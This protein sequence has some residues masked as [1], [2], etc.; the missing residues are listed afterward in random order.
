MDQRYLEYIL[1]LA[2]TGNMTRAAQKLYISQPALS[3]GIRRIEAELGVTLFVRDRTKVVP[4]AAA[5]QVAKEGMPL[6]LKVE[7][8]TQSIINQGT[9]VAY[10]VRIGLSQFYGHHMLGKTLKSF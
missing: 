3:Q 4:T 8:L 2:E 6:V 9:D 1:V 7:A 10:H 5:L